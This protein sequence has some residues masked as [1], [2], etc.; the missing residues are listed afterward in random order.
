MKII[1]LLLFLSL[2]PFQLLYA[3]NKY[4]K[5]PSF[6][7]NFNSKNLDISK[8][9]I[10]IAEFKGHNVFFTKDNFSIKNGIL[11]IKLKKEKRNGCDYTSSSIWTQPNAIKF[12]CGKLMVRAMIP[13]TKD[14]RPAIWLK[15]LNSNKQLTGE[16]DILEHWPDYNSSKYQA[17]FHLWGKINNEKTSHIQYPYIV[18]NFDISKWHV[19]GLE[20]DKK[21]ITMKVDNKIVAQW[22][23]S[24][25][26]DW[27]IGINYQL[28]ISLSCSTW[29]TNHVK[30]SNTLPQTMKIKWIRYYKLK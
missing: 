18:E 8:W 3:Q 16:I 11:N 15:A 17:N 23:K 21:N 12:N 30:E 19:Y 2:F 26:P 10:D 24:Q 20:W 5:K 29:A 25:L 22:S 6:E 7:E 1:K 14:C 4:E 28:C 9:G 13:A 27:P